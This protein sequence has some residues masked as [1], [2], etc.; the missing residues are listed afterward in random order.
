MFIQAQDP[1]IKRSRWVLDPNLTEMN[2]SKRAAYDYTKSRT[3]RQMNDSFVAAYGG[4]VVG[5]HL[6]TETVAIGGLT[7]DNVPMGIANSTSP[8]FRE[9]PFVGLLGLGPRPIYGMIPPMY[10]WSRSGTD[11]QRLTS[12]LR[13][14]AQ[15]LPAP[16]SISEIQT[17]ALNFKAV[18]SDGSASIEF[19]G[20]DHNQYAGQLARVPLNSTDGHWAV[21]NVDFSIG[22][23]RMNT[24]AHVALGA[25]RS[26]DEDSSF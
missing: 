24:K 16:F 10:L 4:G 26:I 23:V 15:A 21:D 1:L 8:Y 25:C 14:P 7:F 2:S 22:N 18:G 5:G 17:F 13:A 6:I 9:Q 20:I 3:V 11:D 12:H 19:G